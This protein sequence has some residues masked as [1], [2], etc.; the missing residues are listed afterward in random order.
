MVDLHTDNNGRLSRAVVTK[1]T[2][3]RAVDE[4]AKQAAINNFHRR[5][6][7]PRRQNTTYHQPVK[8]YDPEPAF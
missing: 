2:G 7:M 4:R 6:I 8:V 1:S 3:D 5:V